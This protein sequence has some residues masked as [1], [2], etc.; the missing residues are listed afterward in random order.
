MSAVET[1]L[2]GCRG[3]FAP[4]PKANDER[5]LASGTEAAGGGVFAPATVEDMEEPKDQQGKFFYH[6]SRDLYRL[7][8]IIRV[9]LAEVLSFRG[10]NEYSKKEL[11]ALSEGNGPFVP[12]FVYLKSSNT[13]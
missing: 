6:L 11:M 7:A 1:F 4:A 2:E 12:R 5:V 10:I 13:T 3:V 9:I 8:N